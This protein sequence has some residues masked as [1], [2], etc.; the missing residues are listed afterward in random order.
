MRVQ[1][2]TVVPTDLLARFYTAKVD[3]GKRQAMTRQ[4][5]LRATGFKCVA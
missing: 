3:Y 4:I 2:R 1:H 5:G